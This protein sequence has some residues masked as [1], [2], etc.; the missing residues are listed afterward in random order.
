[1]AGVGAAVRGKLAAIDTAPF[2]YYLEENPAYLPLADELFEAIDRREASGL[3]S[4]LTLLELA[5]KPLREG[6]PRLADS[7]RRILTNAADLTL[8]PL[9]EAV[10]FRAAQLRGKY[11]RL[12][13]PDAIQIA[14]AL[15]HGAHLIVTNDERWKRLS[16]LPVL[17]LDDHLTVSP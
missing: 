6:D 16:E 3:T 9:D 8:Y 11:P 15:E 1:M 13:T 10:S 5:V 7:Y 12:R 2:I 14:T 4:V 17:V